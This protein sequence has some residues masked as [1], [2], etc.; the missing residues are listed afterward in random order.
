MCFYCKF[1]LLHT[2][3]LDAAGLTITQPI[4][5][6]QFLSSQHRKQCGLMDFGFEI[7]VLGNMAHKNTRCIKFPCD[8]CHPLSTVP[9]FPSYTF[10]SWSLLGTLY[11]ATCN[12]RTEHTHTHADTNQTEWFW[13]PRLHP[14]SNV[15]IAHQ[16]LLCVLKHC[17][18]HYGSLSKSVRWSTQTSR[19]TSLWYL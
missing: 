1:E 11:I 16:F 19:P 7:C 8:H 14:G 18:V 3:T 5:K 17:D 4:Q 9:L 10:D 6:W 2:R 12:Q 13:D 15:R